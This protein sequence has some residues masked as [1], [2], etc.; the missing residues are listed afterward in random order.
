M[1]ESYIFFFQFSESRFIAFVKKKNR[2]TKSNKQGDGAMF[3]III[4][5]M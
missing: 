4:Y 1:F 5:F 2:I 3:M